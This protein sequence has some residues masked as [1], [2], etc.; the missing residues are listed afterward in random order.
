M[1]HN[2]D[3]RCGYL[4]RMKKLLDSRVWSRKGQVRLVCMMLRER[5]YS[6]CRE[7]YWYLIGTSTKSVENNSCQPVTKQRDLAFPPRK[8]QSSAPSYGFLFLNTSFV[9]SGPCSNGTEVRI[10]AKKAVVL[11]LNGNAI[12]R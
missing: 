9:R 1:S 10:A 7:K 11:T 8:A 2:R 5:P 12:V 6:K 3:R 4:P